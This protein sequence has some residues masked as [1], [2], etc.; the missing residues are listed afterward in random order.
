[1][2]ESKSWSG[3]MGGAKLFS[4]RFRGSESAAPWNQS[5]ADDGSTTASHE[6]PIDSSP[7]L[8]AE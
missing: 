3:A 1:M 5:S 6:F 4:I 2:G 8:N 7:N